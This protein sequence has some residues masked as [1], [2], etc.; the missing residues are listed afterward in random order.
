MKRLLITLL[1]IFFSLFAALVTVIGA[2]GIFFAANTP[3]DPVLSSLPDYA[4]K[5]YV[6]AGHIGDFT[7]Y[8]K[9]TYA[10]SA[11]DLA[12]NPYLKPV[13]E[14]DLAVI[15]G[16]LDNFEN[17]VE[18]CTDFPAE[19]YDF[20]RSALGTGD[21]FYIR[22]ANEDPEKLYW[23]YTLYYFDSASGILYYFHNN[24]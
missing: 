14:S 19:Q 15:G 7:D 12:E 17:W 3:Q 22:N 23:N 2:L 10:L 16:Y 4:H 1:V 18:I 21:W 24:I 13:G 6:S 9:Y 20:D 11:T 8:G 5:E